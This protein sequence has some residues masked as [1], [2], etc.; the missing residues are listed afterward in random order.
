LPPS[1]RERLAPSLEEEVG[2]SS[3]YLHA[4]PKKEYLLSLYV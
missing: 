1:S 2:P 4:P 3:I